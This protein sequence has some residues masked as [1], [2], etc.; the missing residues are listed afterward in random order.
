MVGHNSQQIDKITIGE[1]A[2][3]S[4][5]VAL[6]SARNPGVIMDSQ[7]RWTHIAT[8]WCS[9]YY[10]LRLRPVARSLSTDVAKTLVHAFVSSRL[11]C[12]NAL[13]YGVSEGLLLRVQSVQN[14]AARLWLVRGAV[15]TSRRFCGNCM[16]AGATVSLIQGR[17]PGLPVS[18]SCTGRQLSAH[19][20][21]QHAQPPLNQH[22]DVC[23]STFTQHLRRSVFHSGWTASVELIAF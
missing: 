6:D 14:A 22:G 7:C 11:D 18:I 15:I 17:C 9:G 23:W 12:C 1:K 21:H 4:T 10:Q 20:W 13:L 5:A 2:A 3:E 19:R 16:V 8:L